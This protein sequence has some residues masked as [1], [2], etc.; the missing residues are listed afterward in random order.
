M[1]PLELAARMGEGWTV[2]DRAVVKGCVR[3]WRY[4]SSGRYGA[5]FS[6]SL[7]SSTADAE[8][9][10]LAVQKVLWS[11][12]NFARMTLEDIAAVDASVL[13]S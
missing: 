4:P 5:K 9:P 7:T 12:R 10:E 2:N 6:N 1:T 13:D 3:V 11:A 8:T